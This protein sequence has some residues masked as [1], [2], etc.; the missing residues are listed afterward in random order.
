MSQGQE[1]TQALID[2]KAAIRA[3]K[4]YV[5][6]IYSS[7]EIKNIGLEEVAFSDD[8]NAWLI[9]IGFSRPWDGTEADRLMSVFETT[10]A[11]V[12]RRTYKKL[13]VSATDGKV[14]SM[15]NRPI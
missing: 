6:D 15:E 3:A 1:T 11:N 13:I 9:T 5:A 4:Q 14:I 12:L 2:V 8:H 10:A 7:D